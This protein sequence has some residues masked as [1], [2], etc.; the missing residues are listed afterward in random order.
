[1]EDNAR[2][3]NAEQIIKYVFASEQQDYQARGLRCRKAGLVQAK[4]RS[5]YLLRHFYPKMTWA[6][7]GEYFGQ[8]HD[9]AIYNYN[10]VI[11]FMSVDKKYSDEIMRYIKLIR[12]SGKLP[13][14]QV[15]CT[16]ATYRM[17]NKRAILR[18]TALG[19]EIKLKRLVDRKV[20]TRALSISAE[21]LAGIVE[22]YN[23][24]TK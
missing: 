2:A 17:P 16:S 5:V 20:E 7:T 8:G 21:A 4:Q 9:M 15:N 6:V 1:M 10:K 18:K 19:Y 14:L 23:T 13:N 24:L 3:M 12:E 11:A 22:A